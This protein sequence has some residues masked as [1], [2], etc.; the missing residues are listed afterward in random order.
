MDPDVVVC[1]V[2][3]G[4][5]VDQAALRRGVD[6][7]GKCYGEEGEECERFPGDHGG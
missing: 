1:W 3:G 6:V 4:R 2:C 7:L 5:D